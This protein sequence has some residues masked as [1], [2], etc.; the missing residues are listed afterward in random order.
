MN[1][2]HAAVLAWIALVAAAIITYGAW[3]LIIRFNLCDW[4]YL[5]LYPSCWVVP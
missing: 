4:T 3:D 1:A 2:L 5:N